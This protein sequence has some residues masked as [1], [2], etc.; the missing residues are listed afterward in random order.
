MSQ[1]WY[2]WVED[3]TQWWIIFHCFDFFGIFLLLT[4]ALTLATVVITDI[5]VTALT[6]KSSWFYKLVNS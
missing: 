1:S 3:N 2:I 6:A 4:H 5:T